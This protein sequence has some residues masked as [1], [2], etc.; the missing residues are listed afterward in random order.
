MSDALSEVL[1]AVRLKGAVFFDV[2]ARDPWVAEAPRAATVAPYIMP[3]L[4]HVIEYHVVTEGACFGG[5][6]GGEAVALAAG[7]VVVF[8]HG[9]AHVMSSAPGMRTEPD[10]ALLEQLGPGS[11][12]IAITTGQGARSSAKLICG[13]LGCDARPFSPLLA[14]LPRVL[15]VRASDGVASQFMSVALAES[16][17]LTAGSQCVLARLSEL[18]FIDAI[19]RYL[20]KL[21]DESKGFLAG[22]RDPCVGRALSKLHATPARAWTLEELAREA[23]TSRSMLADRFAELVGVPPMQYLAQWR[24]HL[25][26]TA[27]TTTTRGLSEIAAEVGYSSEAALSRAFKRELGVAPA[28]W[29][30]GERSPREVVS[31]E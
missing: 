31:N 4:D 8:P 13:F 27:L 5:L 18:M 7:D 24:V 20:S 3:G 12:P 23:G 21:S 6:V 19:R 14:H 26:A 17:A 28:L 2:D 11:L 30:K 16:G 1:R 29:R 10:I 25:A 15:H 9:D 22:L